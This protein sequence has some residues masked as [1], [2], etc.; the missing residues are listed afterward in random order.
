MKTGH[1][2][3]SRPG[4]T[5]AADAGRPRKGPA[6]FL[7]CC[8]LALLLAGLPVRLQPARAATP[9][10]FIV[11]NSSID[12]KNG[13]LVISLGLDVE[14]TQKLHDMLKNGAA[15][16][17]AANVKLERLRALWTNE[18][19][20]EQSFVSHLRHNPLTREFLITMPG[21][22]KHLADRNL[23]RLLAATWHNLSLHIGSRDM[24]LRYGG[25][26]K[27]RITLDLSLR[28]TEIPPWLAK[29]LIFRSWDIAEPITL[30][31]P[32]TL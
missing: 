12:A 15:M 2:M 24:L 18:T 5:P 25:N 13:S 10:H 31:I 16:L 9:E 14:N 29:T 32:F 3:G 1:A 8:G 20:R 23:E 17:L 11:K 7:L 26:T 4:H 27:Y 28:H 30:T 19:I 21:G 22:E 6:A